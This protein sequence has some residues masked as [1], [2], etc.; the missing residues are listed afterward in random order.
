M[1]DPGDKKSTEAAR[2]IAYRAVGVDPDPKGRNPDGSDYHLMDAI[3]E[4]LDGTAAKKKIDHTDSLP[5]NEADLR[6]R[7]K[8]Q[9]MPD[10]GGRY[11]PFAE[12][13]NDALSTLDGKDVEIARMVCTVDG[14]ARMNQELIARLDVRANTAQSELVARL[15]ASVACGPN[16]HQE[17]ADYITELTRRNAEQ[18]AEIRAVR[19]GAK[20]NAGVV[21]RWREEIAARD[22][23]IGR[24]KARLAALEEYA[25]TYSPG[26]AAEAGS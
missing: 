3:D 23:E 24:L 9:T 1:S 4:R 22:V 8:L 14:L 16:M 17:A 6:E 15:R 20:I 18:A 2:R 11:T 21:K 10:Q 26:I 19:D 12:L 7:L 25:D 13:A 5:A